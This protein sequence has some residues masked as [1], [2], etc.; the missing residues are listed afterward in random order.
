MIRIY[1]TNL[2]RTE[3]IELPYVPKV[4]TIPSPVNTTSFENINGEVLTLIGAKG[5][6]SFSLETFFP[7][8]RY[9]W[10]GSSASLASDCIEFFERY[11]LEPLRVVVA[12]EQRTYINML[13]TL[14]D[15]DI[16]EKIN[17]DVDYTINVLEYIDP[18][19]VR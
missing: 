5:L 16:S 8:K 14:P 19:G 6:K 11:R 9:K 3:V 7:S 2:L 1:F 13:C 4:P 18:V 17:E 12:S 10:L 15:F